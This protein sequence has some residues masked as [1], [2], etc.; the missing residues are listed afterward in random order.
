MLAGLAPSSLAR[1]RFP[2]AS[3]AKPARPRAGRL[4]R[5]RGRRAAPRARTSASSPARASASSCAA[6]PASGS[7][8]A[9]SSTPRATGS[10]H[11]AATTTSPSASAAASASPRSEPLYVLGTD[12]ASNRVTVGP[13][14]QLR[15]GSVRLR[16]AR[17]HREASRV[18]SVR[19][20]Y[21]S[22]LAALPGRVTRAR[23]RRHARSG[24][25]GR[26]R[27]PR[28]GR[29][30]DGRRPRRRPRH[31]R[32]DM[33][34]RAGLLAGSRP[35][36]WL[37]VLTAVG[38]V[39]AITAL[40]YPR[41]GGC[42]GRLDRRPLSARGA[43]DLDH[44]GLV[45]GAGDLGWP[46][47]SRSTSST[48][49]P[50]G[51]FT[52]ARRRELGRAG[53][54]LHR[55]GRRELAGRAG[56]NA[57]GRGG[58]ERG[59]KAQENLDRLLEANREREA[60]EAE[61]IEARALRRSD[62]L[63]TALLRSVSHDLRSPLTAILAAGEALGSPSVTDEDRTA[64]AETIGIEGSRL[65]RGGREPSRPLQARG[66]RRRAA[67]RLDLDR[68]GGPDRGRAGRARARRQA[69]DRS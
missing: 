56:A 54:L 51:E 58:E 69:L 52:I 45:A 5:A 24:G 60:L 40:I 25:A 59:R 9:M 35:P 62:E 2:L 55:G 30:P 37:G 11:T 20:R 22:P 64:L 38:A 61:A 6:T 3:L 49:H 65:T 29:L 68:G 42:A 50:T 33:T 10:A 57:G 47:R 23:R 16:G 12:A 34:G 32:L 17:L 28:P 63:K 41:A 4:R 13:A 15:R 36:I 7:G 53:H 39:A 8:R 43:G 67:P 27:R 44:L 1:L 21:H 14:E 31:D 19:L 18:D 26:R 66:G 48:S 46:A